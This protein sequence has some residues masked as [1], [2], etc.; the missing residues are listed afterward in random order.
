MVLT[1]KRKK[2]ISSPRGQCLKRPN[3]QK[4]PQPHQLEVFFNSTNKVFI[5]KDKDSP[6][7][8]FCFCFQTKF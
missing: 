3:Y 4:Y 5:K 1:L 7:I 2:T 6:G 8:Q